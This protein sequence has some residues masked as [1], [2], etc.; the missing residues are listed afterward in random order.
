MDRKQRGGRRTDVGLGVLGIYKGKPGREGTVECI[1]FV[2]PDVAIVQARTYWGNVTTLDHGTRVPP[3]REIDTL[4]VVQ[5]RGIWRVASINI[6]NQMPPFD[7]KPG[8]SLDV[9]VPPN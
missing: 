9:P 1:C 6:H 3:H 2:R 5:N 4:V 8:E 7:V